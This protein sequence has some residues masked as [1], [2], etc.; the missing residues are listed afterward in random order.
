MYFKKGFRN[1]VQISI[2]DRAYQ[3]K[4]MEQFGK[5]Y[6]GSFWN[7]KYTLKGIHV[8]KLWNQDGLQPQIVQSQSQN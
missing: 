7:L 2:D 6:E 3:F 4:Q 8:W 1:F 5:M